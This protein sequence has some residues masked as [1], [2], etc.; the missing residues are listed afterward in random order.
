MVKKQKI[1]KIDVRYIRPILKYKKE[2]THQ[3]RKTTTNSSQQKN[4]PKT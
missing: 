4:A 1:G 3:Y 2:L